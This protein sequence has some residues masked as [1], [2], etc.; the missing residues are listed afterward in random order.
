MD[1]PHDPVSQD[2]V[3][4]CRLMTTHIA[5]LRAVNLPRH[6]KVAMTDLRSLPE[7]LGFTDGQTLLQSGN[8]VFRGGTLT[9]T[10]LE[11]RL[12]I[13]AIRRFDLETTFFVRT[14]AEWRALIERNPFPSEAKS[15][16]GHLVVMFLAKAVKADQVSALQDA[17]TGREIARGTGRELYIIYPDGIGRSRVTNLL[18]ERKLDTRCTGRNWN[19]VLKL[20]AAANR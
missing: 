20:N 16:P 3:A 6:G 15:D 12:E 11:R 17:I 4:H 8:L 14:A 7:S 18:I 5:L 2:L 13:E 19:T 1:V 9:G 10:A